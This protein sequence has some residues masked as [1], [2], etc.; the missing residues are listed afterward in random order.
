MGVVD[1][2]QPDIAHVGGITALWKVSAAA[3]ASGIRMAP[4]ACE[5]PIGGI[6]SLHVDAAIAE[7]PGAGDLRLR[8]GG[9]EQSG[10]GGSAR[11]SRHAD[12]RTGGI[13]FPPG[14]DWA[15]KSVKR[16]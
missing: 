9:R 15:S 1:I 8:R 6:A 7:F 4:H 5:G 12:G 3:E 11:V 10:L 14:R 13:L 2:L 16:R